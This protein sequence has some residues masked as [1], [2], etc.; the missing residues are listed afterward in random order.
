MDTFNGGLVFIKTISVSRVRDWLWNHCTGSWRT[1]ITDVDESD[2]DRLTMRLEVSFAEPED[3]VSFKRAFEA[4]TDDA[5]RS[6]Y[7]LTHN[8]AAYPARVVSGGRSSSR[9]YASRELAPW[10]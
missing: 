6:G 4:S 3:C 10:R 2:P 7:A 8:G 5:R 1:R 9:G